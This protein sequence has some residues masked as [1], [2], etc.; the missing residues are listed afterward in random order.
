MG[1]FLSSGGVVSVVH[2]RRW[3]WYDT[4]VDV[5]LYVCCGAE[6][7]SL[8]FND[9]VTEGLWKSGVWCPLRWMWRVGMSVGG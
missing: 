3:W 4:W 8:L 1:G 2:V 6:V 7:S 5:C 9:C